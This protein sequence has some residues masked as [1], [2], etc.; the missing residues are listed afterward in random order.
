MRRKD[1]VRALIKLRC[2]NPEGKNKYWLEKK[3]GG[4]LFCNAGEDNLEHYVN[5]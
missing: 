4:C 2:G 3:R 5:E 1:E